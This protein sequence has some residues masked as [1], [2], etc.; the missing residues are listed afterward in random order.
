M[1]YKMTIS[2][3]G[4]P[5][6]PD[7][8]PADELLIELLH[9]NQTSGKRVLHMGPGLHHHVGLNLGFD[10]F[11]LALTNCPEEIASYVNL[12][13][14]DASLNWYYQVQFSD[15]H[16]YDFRNLP[17]FDVVTLFHLG[18]F[19]VEDYAPLDIPDVIENAI[20]LLNPRG[21]LIGYT[22]SS[23]W[24][25]AG[26]YFADI[27]DAHRLRWRYNYGSLK[28]WQVPV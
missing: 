12:V 5:W 21:I 6:R 18:E 8:C 16:N 10:N 25:R 22:G 7:L 28:I 19:P 4:W 24:D 11:V 27:A 23:A 9:K 15:I 20:G 1:T 26:S 2:K 14:E 13:K 3:E 17:R